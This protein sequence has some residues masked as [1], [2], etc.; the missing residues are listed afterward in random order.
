[1]KG[2]SN[3]VSNL[4][5]EDRNIVPCAKLIEMSS[6]ELENALGRKPKGKAGGFFV[7]L[8]KGRVI[9]YR[10]SWRAQA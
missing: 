1:M 8:E 3:K 10:P 6:K 4:E 2:F 9:T 7:F 5:A